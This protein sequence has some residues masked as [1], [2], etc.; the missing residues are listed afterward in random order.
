MLA[1]A[2]RG[3]PAGV[4]MGLANLVPGISGG[5]MLVAAGIYP[6]FIR[7]VSDVTRLR[8]SPASLMLLATVALGALLAIILL[9]DTVVWAVTE[10]RWVM[11][12]LFIGLTLGGLP[13]LWRLA[14]TPTRSLL[15]GGCLGLIAMTTLTL[16][17]GAG[18]GESVGGGRSALLLVLAGA[19]GASAMILPGVS[20]AYLLLVLG[21]YVPILASIGRLEAALRDGNI[22]AAWAEAETLAPVA[23][24]VL[25]GVVGVSN[26]LRVLLERFE[27]PT[28]GVLM[29]LL[30]GAVIGLWPFQRVVEPVIGETVIKGVL[31]TA[32]N[33]P[34][35]DRAEYPTEAFT[36]D[37]RQSAASL[38][39]VCGGF[40]VTLLIARLGRTSDEPAA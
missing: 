8:F 26:L 38:G 13:L 36:P 30:L 1:D 39:L 24:G 18:S 12:S 9:A 34:Q 22:A 3:L 40:L 20:G 32:E 17:Q 23:L 31:V 19:A 11:Y 37:A 4:L 16:L 2:A 25:I 21:Q 6:R 5:T 27:K 35:F 15:I 10:H 7:A 29:G 33:R 28:L 14:G